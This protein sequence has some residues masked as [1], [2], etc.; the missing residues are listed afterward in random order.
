MMSFQ[1]STSGASLPSSSSSMK[2]RLSNALAFQPVG[3]VTPFGCHAAFAEIT[4]TCSRSGTSRGS[5]L[6]LLASTHPSPAFVTITTLLATCIAFSRQAAASLPRLSRSHAS[7]ESMSRLRSPQAVV[8]H[9]ES[10]QSKMIST[11]ASMASSE[12]HD[13][14]SLLCP[15]THESIPDDGVDGSEPDSTSVQASAR[16]TSH[17]TPLRSPLA[18]RTTW[19]NGCGNTATLSGFATPSLKPCSCTAAAAATSSGSLP[20]QCITGTD[21]HR[22][23]PN[24]PNPDP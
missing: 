13:Q 23:A 6:L 22:S 5:H 11:P 16:L 15:F 17:F 14:R 4:S 7:S 10:S 19:P 1:S 3:E 20:S 9:R 12:L 24:L 8:G 2:A 21:D 18:P